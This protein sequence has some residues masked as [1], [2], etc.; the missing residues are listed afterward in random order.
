MDERVVHVVVLVV[1][2]KD[3]LVVVLETGGDRLP[4]RSKVSRAGD[5]VAVVAAVVV[6]VDDGVGSLGGDVLDELQSKFQHTISPSSHRLH[7]R[8][9][10]S[11][12]EK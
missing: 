9:T 5:D 8:L 10:S 3:D 6:G 7:K 4:P 1:G 12:P 11:R 2:V